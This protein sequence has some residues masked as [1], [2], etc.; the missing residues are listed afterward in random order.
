MKRGEEEEEEDLMVSTSSNIDVGT[1]LCP[2]PQQQLT[3]RFLKTSVIG[4]IS[5]E[6]DEDN[7]VVDCSGKYTCPANTAVDCLN[8]CR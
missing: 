7:P 6:D 3:P 5:D 1:P 8:K 2:S 4:E